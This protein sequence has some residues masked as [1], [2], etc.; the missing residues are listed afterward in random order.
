[1][2]EGESQRTRAGILSG[3]S[4][5]GHV[6]DLVEVE[7]GSSRARNR[8]RWRIREELKSRRNESRGREGFRAREESGSGSDHGR[9]VVFMVGGVDGGKLT[10]CTQS[11]PTWWGCC[12]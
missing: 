9:R 7:E 6:G 3:D 1:M 4:S 5:H 8:V 12:T 2:V 11:I 10:K